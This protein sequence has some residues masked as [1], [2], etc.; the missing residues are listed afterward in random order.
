MPIA[1]WTSQAESDLEEIAFYIA[2]DDKRPAVADQIVNERYAQAALYATQPNMGSDAAELGENL[3][4]FPHKRW[5]VIYEPIENGI[6][7]RTVVD[8]ARDYPNWRTKL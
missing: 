3:R 8:A 4:T 1:K 2:I 6:R 5:L 7:V